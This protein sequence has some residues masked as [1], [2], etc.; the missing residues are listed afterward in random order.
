MATLLQH[1]VTEHA[2]LTPDREAFRH[3]NDSL[4]FA[5]LET[6]SNQLAHTLIAHGVQRGDRVGVFAGRTMKAQFWH[7]F[8]TPRG[9]IFFSN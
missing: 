8:G 9:Q 3:A 4:S 7:S 6:R 2:A 5:E 1:A